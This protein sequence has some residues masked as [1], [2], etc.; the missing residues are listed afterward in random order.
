MPRSGYLWTSVLCASLAPACGSG[1]SG[2]AGHEIV[3]DRSG[4]TN[5]DETVQR[6]GSPCLCCHAGEF[7]VAGS[8]DPASA[9][10]AKVLVV[11]RAGASAEMA[12][13]PF[14]NFFR[15]TFLE[16]PLTA[17]IVAADGRSWTMQDAP[18]GDCNG[19]HRADGAA[20]PLSV[21][22]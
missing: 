1:D 9:P 15:H 5:G 4:C 13:N 20:L 3:P 12:P 11:D 17:T 21:P 16:P 19:C 7:G 14:G 8:V 2:A 10:V 18:S 6:R 22:P